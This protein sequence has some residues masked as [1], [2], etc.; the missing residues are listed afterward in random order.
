MLLIYSLGLF[1]L[2]SNQASQRSFLVHDGYIFRDS[3]LCVPACSLRVKL[4]SELHGEGHVGRDRTIDLVQRRFFWPS[5]RHDVTQHVQ[6]CRICQQSKGTTT[7]ARLYRPLL[8][9][10]FPWAAVSMDF[11]LG[12]PCTQCGLTLFSS[13]LIGSPKWLTLSRV[14]ALVT[15]GS[16]F[17]SRGLPPPWSAHFYSF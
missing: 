2:K 12:L 15:R 8:V 13:L 11:I 6:R 17:F 9:P 4:V 16:T 10:S 1:F 3:R 7:D 5:L 14:S